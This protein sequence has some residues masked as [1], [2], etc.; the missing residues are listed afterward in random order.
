[1]PALLDAFYPG[2]EGGTAIAEV[3]LGK[4]NP[5]G[6]LPFTWEKR[7]EDCPAYGN[8]PT[9]QTPQSNTY[10]EGVFA[11]YRGFDAKG[12][13]P[14]FPFGFGLSYTTF[15]FSNAA[16][17]A[18]DK[19]DVKVTATVRNSGSRTGAEVVQVYVEPPQGGVARPV[20]ELKAFTKISLAPGE[21]KAVVLTIPHDELAYWDPGTKGWVV[22][23]GSYTA[24][25]GDSSRSLP[26]KAGFT[27]KE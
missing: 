19:G 20:R 3:L 13:E 21:S 5:S 1:V 4:T 16:A 12:T 10:K 25:V 14:L 8:Y 6:K 9:A 26:V 7:W 17:A 23:A 24:R 11:G 22:T 2:Q 15:D 27:E 18:D